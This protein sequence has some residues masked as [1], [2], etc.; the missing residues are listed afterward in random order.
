MWATAGLLSPVA[1]FLP[2]HKQPAE[3]P[4]LL[5]AEGEIWISQITPLMGIVLA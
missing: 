4:Q 1:G 5:S 3:E 2:E